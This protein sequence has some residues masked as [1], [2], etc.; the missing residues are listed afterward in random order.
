MPYRVVWEPL[1]VLLRAIPFSISSL[2][3]SDRIEAA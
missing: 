1:W 2:D 3:G